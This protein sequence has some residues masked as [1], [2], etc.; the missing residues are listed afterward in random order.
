MS[1]Q[2][3]GSPKTPYHLAGKRVWVTGHRGMVGSALVRRLAGEQCEILTVDPRTGRSEAAGRGRRL[4]A[5]AKPQAVFVAAATVGGI[6]A[7]D[8]LSGRVPLRQPDDRGQYHRR[9]AHGAGVEKLLFLGSSCIYPQAGAA[10]DPGGRP[11]DR[12]AR[13]DQRVVRHRQDRRHQAV[14]GLSPPARLRFHLGRC[15]PTSTVPA[16]TSTCSSSH[17]LPALMRKAH[18]AKLRGDATIVDV[19]HRHARGASSCTSDDCA[20]ALVFL[21]RDLFRRRARQRRLGRG[22]DA[23]ASWPSWLR[24]RRLHRAIDHDT[25]KP[26]GT[27]RKLMDG[28]K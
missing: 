9:P 15:R 23:S 2:P 28:E 4:D 17:V 16:T 22:P 5:A 8:S 10:A 21:L 6:L 1:P 19:G 18:E 3:Q 13:A 11:A 12:P 24:S 20:D 26:D 27:P 14:P 7:N 25:S